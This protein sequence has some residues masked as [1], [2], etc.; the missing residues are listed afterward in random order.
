M[1]GRLVVGL[2]R[3]FRFAAVGVR[4]DVR[5]PQT[6]AGPAVLVHVIVD[7][8]RHSRGG[9]QK[10]ASGQRH[11]RTVNGVAAGQVTAAAV[12]ERRAARAQSTQAQRLPD[13][14]QEVAQKRHTHVQNSEQR[15]TPVAAVR[16]LHVP[17]QILRVTI[18]LSYAYREYG[19]RYVIRC[20]HTPHRHQITV[21]MSTFLVD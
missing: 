21:Y 13:R 14:R 17:A 5:V 15:V 7:G 20:T 6:V 10:T 19:H 2:G 3:H 1:G 8:R 12:Q 16:Y 11:Y 9:N 4:A 18:S